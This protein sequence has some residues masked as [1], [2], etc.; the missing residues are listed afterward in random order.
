MTLRDIVSL[1]E[2]IKKDNGTGDP[3]E[4]CRKKL[5]QAQIRALLTKGR[6]PCIKGFRSKAG[7]SFSAVLYIDQTDRT[8]RFE[9]S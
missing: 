1:A 6:T 3:A 7:K 4:I 8:V 2:K 5:T 9:F